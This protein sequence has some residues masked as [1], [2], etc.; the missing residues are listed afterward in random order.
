[1]FERGGKKSSNKGEEVFIE[2]AQQQKVTRYPNNDLKQSILNNL[3]VP[4]R[5]GYLSFSVRPKLHGEL[6]YAKKKFADFVQEKKQEPDIDDGS[7]EIASPLNLAAAVPIPLK[8]S[9]SF[10][11]SSNIGFPVLGIDMTVETFKNTFFT[12][13]ISYL[14][15]EIIAQQRLLNRKDI[16]MAIGPHYRLQRRWLRVIEGPDESFGISTIVSLLTP[17][18][19]YYN[20]TVGIRSVIYLPVTKD[21]FLHI[22]V[23][24]GYATNV[25]EFTINLGLS[26][27]YQLW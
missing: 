9:S 4:F 11:L 7:F 21:T 2:K 22:V 13:N 1:M 19:T 18:R 14:S 6:D 10:A 8:R 20:H 15:G 5:E 27:K 3:Y 17:A 24:P 16:G 12:A 25:D 23:A 26:L